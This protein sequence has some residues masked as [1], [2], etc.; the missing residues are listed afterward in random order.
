MKHAPV[1]STDSSDQSEDD[2]NQQQRGRKLDTCWDDNPQAQKK[3]G[4]HCVK[5]CAPDEPPYTQKPMSKPSKSCCS[6]VI[7]PRVRLCLSKG[8]LD[9]LRR[10]LGQ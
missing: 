9:V 6:D 2:D 10:A 4:L 5:S 1:S 3:H 7:I 8:A